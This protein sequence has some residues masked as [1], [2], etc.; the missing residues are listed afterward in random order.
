MGQSIKKSW[1]NQFFEVKNVEPET[2][3][4]REIMKP[5]VHGRER[6]KD[7]RYYKKK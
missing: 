1:K 6:I 3:G 7:R 2:D 5:P 4:E